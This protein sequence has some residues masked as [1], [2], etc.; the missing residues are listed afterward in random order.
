VRLKWGGGIAAV[1]FALLIAFYSWELWI[2]TVHPEPHAKHYGTGYRVAQKSEPDTAEERIA[3]WTIWLAVFTGLLAFISMIQIWFLTRA[4]KT[5]TDY[6][7][8]S[9]QICR[10]R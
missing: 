6:R 4:D 10:H 2:I 1:L 8:R 9:V 5:A 7:R 3:Y